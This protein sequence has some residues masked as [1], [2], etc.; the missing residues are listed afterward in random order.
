MLKTATL[1]LLAGQLYGGGFWLELGNPQA[2]PEARKRNA[3]LTVRATGCHHPEAAKIT[4]T[5][6]GT[7]NGRPRSIPLEVVR[8]S[9][10]GVFAVARQWPEA[11]RW[12]IELV[13]KNGEQLTN[14]LVPAGPEGVDRNN[15]RSQ[16]RRFTTSDV[17]ALLAS[18]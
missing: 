10:P 14:T 9:E 3:V 5:A 6:F 16:A 17:Q 11:G 12:V 7:V 4:A 2:N 18:R 1:V 8:L 15:A 13:G